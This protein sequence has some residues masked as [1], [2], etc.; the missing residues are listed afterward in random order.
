MPKKKNDSEEPKNPRQP[1]RKSVPDPAAPPPLKPHGDELP[2]VASAAPEAA[3]T[4]RPAEAAKKKARSIG[5]KLIRKAVPRRKKVEKEET[6]ERAEDGSLR[7]AEPP[8]TALPEPA[9]VEEPA[10]GGWEIGPWDVHLFNEGTHRHLFEKLGAHLIT[11]DGVEGVHFAVWAPSA[12]EVSV[13]GEFNDWNGEGHPL[14][15]VGGS[16]IWGGFI[17]GIEKGALY[18][19]QIVSNYNGY[20]VAKSDPFG[21]LHET[22][23]Q[24]ASRVWDLDYQWNDDQWMASRAERNSPNAPMSVYEVHLGSWRRKAE[25][26]YRSL[27][28]RELAE[29]LTAHVTELGFTHV[30]FLPV[31]E[32]PFFGSWGYQSTGYFAPTSRF[33]TPQDL[34]YLIDQLHQNGIGVILDWVPSHFPTDEHGL[35]Y[36]DGTHLFEHADPRQGFHPD[37]SSLIFNYGRNEVRSFLISSAMFWLDKYHADGLRVDAVASM[38]Y[39]D[40]SRKEGEWIPNRYGGRDNLEALEFLRQLNEAVYGAFP[41]VQMIAEESTAWPM[42]SRPTYLGG[43]GFGMKWDMGWMH[44]TLRYMSHEPVYRKF[45]HNELTFRSIYAFTENFVL[46]LSHDEVVHGKGSLILKMPGDEWQKFANLRLL[47]SYM[48]AQPGKK[49]L[50]MGAELAQVR[51]WNHDGAIDWDLLE[52]PLHAGVKKLLSDLN[53]LY[54]EHPSLHQLDTEPAGFEWLDANDSEQ[55]VLSFIRH[56]KEGDHPVIA[57]FNF[58]PVVRHNYRVGAPLSGWW[59]EIFNSD[60]SEYGGSGQGNLGGIEAAPVPYHGRRHSLNVTLPP[61]G[62]V[63][64]KSAAEVTIE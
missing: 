8:A 28:Y 57:L 48:Y 44:D 12:V 59:D 58:T 45:H 29:E 23:P 54:A 61:L 47:L 16:G 15:A 63:F 11:R 3:E 24:T 19:Y 38:L 10:P 33:G 40:Y 53:R 41:G 62:C 60:A 30:E 22:P 32:H 21:F 25:D 7:P 37:W 9:T 55:S 39:L 35:G 6:L 31:M 13:I 14:Q 20:R 1:R 50:F 52:Y 49:L 36:F 18:K 46:P 34:M 64:L 2:P 56:A 42:V 4:P 17:P 26:G 43:L 51:E 5:Q 27:T